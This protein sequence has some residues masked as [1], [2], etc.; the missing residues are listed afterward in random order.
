MAPQRGNVLALTDT[1]TVARWLYLAGLRTLSDLDD[2]VRKAGAPEI[3][4]AIFYLMSVTIGGQVY[5]YNGGKDPTA[6]DPAD[7]WTRPGSSFENRTGDCVSA[8]A[9]GS[10]WDRYQPV[11]FAHIYDGWINT[12][13]MRIDAS[14]QQRCF[15]RIERPEPGAIVVYASDPHRRSHG[16]PVGHCGGITAYHRAEWE[17]SDAAC[18]EAIEVVNIAAYK[19]AK[20]RPIQANR[21][22]TGRGWFN[23]DAWFLRSI[24]QP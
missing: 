17:P 21:L 4:P 1:Q 13:S 8:V 23:K 15:R 14:G 11:R 3:C 19:D 12:D 7:R 10:G 6:P 9:W 22:T 5:A 20:G 18:W 16:V 2:H 24:M